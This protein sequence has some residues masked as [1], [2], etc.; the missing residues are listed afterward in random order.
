MIGPTARTLGVRPADDIPVI[1]GRVTPGTGCTSVALDNPMNLPEHRRPPRFGGT[2]KDPVW[3]I[4]CAAFGD[5]IGLRSDKPTH[6]LIEPATEMSIE[7]FQAALSNLAP[8][9][10]K[11]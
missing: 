6:G 1:N 3:A 9:W 4:E 2:G 11:L 5:D 8:E 7:D 10:F